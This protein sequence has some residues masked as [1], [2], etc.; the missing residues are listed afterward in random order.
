M[1]QDQ[2]NFS[3]IQKAASPWQPSGALAPGLRPAVA[4]EAGNPPG[5]G[6]SLSRLLAL[7]EPLAHP[8][9]VN[10][11]GNLLMAPADVT[12][13]MA[14]QAPNALQMLGNLLPSRQGVGGVVERLGQEMQSPMKVPGRLV[15]TVGKKMRGPTAATT[16]T[17]VESAATK[18]VGGASR[19]TAVS[20]KAA[21]SAPVESVS[22]GTPGP[23]PSAPPASP[24]APVPQTVSELILTNEERTALDRLVQQGY[25]R[26]RVLQSILKNR[27]PASASPA[28]TVLQ[29]PKPKLNAAEAKE[30]QR[31]IRAGKSEQEA[32]DLIQQMKAMQERLGLPTSAQTRMSV[33]D[34]NATGRWDE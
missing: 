17:V 27:Q 26:K 24:P 23:T 30:F 2:Y 3:G 4:D 13:G 9:T 11:F 21:S 8:Q 10:D 18:P 12:R 1:G 19:R 29:S 33:L 6:D 32:W 34:R 14:P 25:S 28:Q 16:D 15:E 20:A 31:L 5:V 7:L 22:S